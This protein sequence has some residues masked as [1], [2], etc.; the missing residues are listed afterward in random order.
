MMSLLPAIPLPINVVGL[1]LNAKAYRVYKTDDEM[2]ACEWMVCIRS[3]ELMLLFEKIRA[4]EATGAFTIEP[5]PPVQCEASWTGLIY[6]PIRATVW[7]DVRVLVWDTISD[8]LTDEVI[9]RMWMENATH[10]LLSKGATAEA[11]IRITETRVSTVSG[12]TP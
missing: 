3:I 12:T 4:I 8:A 7:G 2:V 9:E 11:G 5:P 6:E 10:G 1:L